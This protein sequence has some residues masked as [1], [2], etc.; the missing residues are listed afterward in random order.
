MPIT[1][2]LP[3]IVVLISL[4]GL[5]G[6]GFHAKAQPVPADTL[7]PPWQTASR[8]ALEDEFVMARLP[9]IMAE[10]GFKLTFDPRTLQVRLD[11]DSSALSVTP[12]VNAVPVG[13]PLRL[14]LH[15]FAQE[16]SEQTFE[17]MWR[18][19]SIES[20]NTRQGVTG[21]TAP[22]TGLSFKLPSPLPKRV[23]SL[24]GPGG[25]AINVAGAENIRLS[26]QS[27][28]TNQQVG[29]LGQK[30]SLFPSLDM[31]QD[32]DIRLEGQLSDRIKVNLLQNSANQVP[33]ANRIFINYKG[34]EDD[35][36]Q[37]LDLGNTS[38]SLP[39]TQYV[40]YSGKN[41]GLFGVK[42]ALRLGPA[43]LT[44]LASR[45]EGRSERA[46]YSGG[47]SSQTSTLADLDYVR[48]VYFMLFDPNEPLPAALLAGVSNPSLIA[49]IDIP[50]ASI[51]VFE[52]DAN[53]SNNINKKRGKA[54]LHPE[55]RGTSVADSSAIRGS[56]SLLNP[57]ADQDYEILR[58]IYGPLFK[59]IRLTHQ[60][61]GEQRL[62]VTYQAR[63]L[64]LSGNPLT[65]YV[66]IG[67][68]VEKDSVDAGG[69]LGVLADTATAL[70]MK[71]LRPPVSALT[72]DSLGALLGGYDPNNVFTAARELE[73]H[74]FY[75][76][77]GQRIDP[78]SFTHSIR[79]GVDQP[80]VTTERLPDNTS[81]PYFELLGLD[82]LNE[83][84]G[85][86]VRGHDNK[87]DGTSINGTTRTFVDSDAGTLFLPD[88]RPFAPR[89]TGPGARPFDQAVSALLFR[90][91]SLVGGP[92]AANAANPAI[93][94][95]YN[96]RRDL[97]TRYY[98]D[99]SFSAAR[100]VGDITLGRGNILEGS[101]V[102]TV[103]GIQWV[104]DR[105]YSI[106]YD[107]GKVTLK[108][109]LAPTD[110]LA[111]NYSYAPL[112]A[113]AG[114]TL[115]GSDFRLE[116]REKHLGAAL[117]YESTGAQDLRPRLGEEP[118]R[119]L[120]G[121]LNTEF[122]LHPDW[123][124]RLVDR[125]PGIRTTTPSDFHVQAEMGA[126][127]PNPNTKD[128]VYI[129]DMEGV[130]DAVSLSLAPESWKHSS[131]P[132]R[133]V[134]GAKISFL[135]LLG[136]H[137]AEIHWYYPTSVV[138]ERD[139]NPDLTD[140]EGGGNSRQVL[141][142]S[143]PRRPTRNNIFE[144]ASHLI[145]AGDPPSPGP[146]GGSPRADTLWAGLTYPLDR[147]GIDLSRAQ[148]IDLWVDDFND[149]HRGGAASRAEPRV[150]GFNVK[151][152]IDVG[153]V[154][155]DEMRAPDE[156][157]NGK[158][159]S[160][161]QPPRDNQLTVAGGINEDTG[162]DGK[163]DPDE[164]GYGSQNPKDW[165]D[166]TTAG[167]GDPEGDDFRP[168][169]EHYKDQLDTRRYRYTN[170]TEGNR[171][172][173]PY[174]D[175][176]DLNLNNNLDTAE[177]Y[178]E[179][180]IELGQRNSPYLETDILRDYAGRPQADSLNGWR[181]YR[182]PL[183]DSPARTMFGSPDLTLARHVRVWVEG[184]MRPDPDPDSVGNDP[185]RPLVMLGGLDIVG[186][187]WQ[188]ALVDTSITTLTLNTVNNIDKTFGYVPPFTPTQPQTGNQPVTPREQS[189]SVEFTDLQPGH[190]VEAFRTF[191]IDEDYS[192][193]KS[194]SWYAVGDRVTNLG[195]A[196]DSIY[197]FVRFASDE[198][199]QSYYEYRSRLPRFNGTP[200]SWQTVELPLTA[201]SGH[202]LDTAYVARTARGQ[203]RYTVVD[204][205]THDTTMVLNGQPSF[206]RLRRIS[207]G[208][209]N[210][211]SQ[212]LPA[213]QL[214]FDEVRAVHVEKDV[215]TANRVQMDGK[216]AN[217]ARYNLS[218]DRRDANFVTLG[219]N[220]GSGSS[221]SQLSLGGGFDVYRFFEGT[222]IVLPVN[223]NYGKSV[224]RPRF[225]A[226]DD[227]VRTGV[228]EAA[229]ETESDN[230]SI[231]TSYSRT[232]NERSNPFLRYTVG[233]LTGSYSYS[234][235][236]G[237]S[238]TSLTTGT[239]RSAVV[240][241][242][243]A[244]RNLLRLPLPYTRLSLF[245]LP[246]RFFWSYNLA[247]TNVVSF[248]RQRDGTLVPRSN[249]TGR[250]ASLS[251]GADTRPVDILHHHFDAVRSLTLPPSQ[252]ERIG[253]INLGRVV[254]WKQNFDSRY[255]LNRGPWLSPSLSWTSNYTQN[256]GPELS[257]DLTVRTIG[258]G[259]SVGLSYALPFDRLAR[260]APGL[261][262]SVH[263]APRFDFR[264]LASRLG[265]FSVDASVNQTSGYS[266]LTGTP[267]LLYLAGL[268]S[269]PGFGDPGH[270]M[271][272]A[273]GSSSVRTTDF[274]T[275]A[276]TRIALGWDAYL[277]TRG[278]YTNRNTNANDLL[279]R[280]TS[281]RF[282]DFDVDYGQV[283]R[284]IQLT[285]FMDNPSLRTS[286]SQSVQTDYRGDI[287]GPLTR[288]ISSQWS[289][290]ISLS[291]N[292]KNQTRTELRIERRVSK[293]ESFQLGHS[294]TTDRNTDVNLNLSR[295]YS[296][297]QKVNLLGKETTVRSNVNLSLAMVY[298]KHSGE[299]VQSGLAT[300]QLPVNQ[301]RLSVTGTG[302]YS[303][304]TNV[305]GNVSLGFG[306]NRD[307]ERD[308]VSRNIRVELRAS[309]TF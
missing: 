145:P 271:Q 5:P 66:N 130:R 229:S 164:P 10:H 150:R 233:G 55:Q 235:S 179:Y 225:T 282:P 52:D 189:L 195:P 291:G 289:P 162:E 213:G 126:S 38:L 201:F 309:F 152:H 97:D 156:P 218:W 308:I 292:F 36:V 22:T 165:R 199:G 208:V 94:D 274:R 4:K 86:P 132:S 105:D 279:T 32:L 224:S 177:D 172:L 248:D 252:L 34:D 21:T 75:Q 198:I 219:Q 275:S 303:F 239:N 9:S 117:L 176:E 221:T 280:S 25:P 281:T 88:P 246:E 241:Y 11:P 231:G 240:G 237:H 8:L 125:L 273:F 93:Y 120:I 158:L 268:V 58:N 302:S 298:S 265:A 206:T 290:L 127:F 98:I 63:L 216:L 83:T 107:I 223:F 190:D 116:G 296:K 89:L 18:K 77:P 185:V 73:M 119:S 264:S 193:Y 41:E 217:L 153:I 79:Q 286:Y 56:F 200:Q 57:G 76:L 7:P 182:I 49:G 146:V 184:V 228:L 166:L 112:F 254:Q 95:K 133:L 159:D 186:S 80:P 106:D 175:T 284:V 178:F 27:N 59:I 161:D 113:Q 71:I 62:A 122:T 20:I 232:W 12:M 67:G 155:E 23:Q 31:Q 242:S 141:A 230:R 78:L 301:D 207:V 147:A 118:S 191:S 1:P 227:I 51:N 3:T 123:V 148:F 163:L 304:S 250:G 272:T 91:D 157:P 196:Q 92:D 212:P 24:L 96:P 13:P 19:R 140:A 297:G 171:N 109:Q 300:P 99:V 270:G 257:P 135:D 214:W 134:N 29:P 144:P 142:L 100:A 205:A 307:I 173:L 35:L 203:F 287:S 6:F 43:D 90:R 259:Q 258:N 249:V 17:E 60:V 103:N 168:V 238:P 226:G 129:D 267:S 181:R 131:V 180:T 277:S 128:Q 187:R 174:P 111:I 44:V 54:L 285:R 47:A 294:T 102:V 74:N 26:G 266:R 108:R 14:P 202:K 209:V 149:W 28:W 30:R 160:E 245:P 255:A 306:Q 70:R 210:L 278:E 167:P 169:D 64:D 234:Q 276:R 283:A 143:I 87:V 215:G 222:G 2:S 114:R 305:T 197:Y 40:S 253:F 82:N 269:S 247:T 288:S 50:D 124:T 243:I 299:T 68:Q 211:S 37:E 194:L 170:G 260:A 48:G 262:D 183:G 263:R 104:R 42:S 53:Y 188:A 72:P 139:L 192:R 236:N 256:N 138:K 101:E 154:S 45:Q 15:D 151:L 244:P 115:I 85:Q 46:T 293:R 251:F 137:N 121:D 110:Q 69:F 65:G 84:T 16:M 39:G 33:L 204:S 136:Q 261:R 61:S 81:I 295:A 220:V